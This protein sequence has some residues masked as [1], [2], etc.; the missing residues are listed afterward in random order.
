MF[1]FCNIPKLESFTNKRTATYV[2]KIMRANDEE[3]PKKFLGAWMEACNYPATT[4]LPKQ[5]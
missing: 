3:L 1:H 2:G 5:S 4:I